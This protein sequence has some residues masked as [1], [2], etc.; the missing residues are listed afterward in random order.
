[1]QFDTNRLLVLD[2]ASHAL[3]RIQE[4]SELRRTVDLRSREGERGERERER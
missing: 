1:M 2:T 4:E 3:L